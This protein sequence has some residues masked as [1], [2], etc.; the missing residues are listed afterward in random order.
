MLIRRKVLDGT[1]LVDTVDLMFF[2]AFLE[3]GC[4]T[5]EGML[6]FVEAILRSPLFSTGG[7]CRVHACSLSASE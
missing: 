6:F 2:E 4:L 7:A 1:E 3:N 5:M